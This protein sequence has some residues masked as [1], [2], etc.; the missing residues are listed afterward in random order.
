MWDVLNKG[1]GIHSDRCGSFNSPHPVCVTV[2]REMGISHRD[3]FRIFPTVI[4][5]RP[6]ERRSD[7]VLYE[8]LG[9]RLRVRLSAESERRLGKLRIPLT[10]VQLQFE[11]FSAEQVESF[12]AAFDLHFHRGGG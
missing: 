10:T 4:R 9:R 6:F 12:M 8:E 1:K 7:G 11:G 3:F 2:T 5:G